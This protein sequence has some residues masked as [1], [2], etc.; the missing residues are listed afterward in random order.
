MVT[1]KLSQRHAS[2]RSGQSDPHFLFGFVREDHG[3][4]FGVH[5]NELHFDV[6]VVD[7]LEHLDRFYVFGRILRLFR[8]DCWCGQKAQH[9]HAANPSPNHVPFHKKN[10]PVIRTESEYRRID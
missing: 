7:C 6:T 5:R 4:L 9:G 1:T 2:K 8:S 10:A 3:A